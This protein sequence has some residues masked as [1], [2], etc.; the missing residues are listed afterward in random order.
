MDFLE[1]LEG[2]RESAEEGSAPAALQRRQ[3][4]ADVAQS[5][6]YAARCSERADGMD[7]AQTCQKLLDWT[8]DN[9]K[10]KKKRICEIIWSEIVRSLLGFCYKKISLS[11]CHY[12][13]LNDVF[14]QGVHSFMHLSWR[15]HPTKE[16]RTT[17][18]WWQ[19]KCRR[20]TDL[21]VRHNLTI[22][23]YFSWLKKRKCLLIVRLSLSRHIAETFSTT[24]CGQLLQSQT[25]DINGE[26]WM[27]T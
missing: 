1:K 12:C 23:G 19:N 9:T 22:K 17:W 11:E 14:K 21:H 6:I 4:A 26:T 16:Q 13:D 18:T 3:S 7:E 24:C 5:G 10:P 20:P 2:L 25:W 15:F 8:K 27:Q